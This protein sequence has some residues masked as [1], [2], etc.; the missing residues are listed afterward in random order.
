[1]TTSWGLLV[2]FGGTLAIILYVVGWY[3]GSLRVRIATLTK[4][5]IVSGAGGSTSEITGRIAPLSNQL[6]KMIYLENALGAIVLF[7]MILAAT[8]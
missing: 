3:A 7:S 4:T 5:A 8:I 2:L 6:T 1:V